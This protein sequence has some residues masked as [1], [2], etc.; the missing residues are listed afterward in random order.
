MFSTY[1]ADFNAVLKATE[2]YTAGKQVEVEDAFEKIID[3]FK[4]IKKQAGVVYLIGNGGSSGIVSHGAIDFLNA[5][6]FRSHALTDNSLLTCMANDYGYENVF[7]QP[8]KTLLREKDAVI[9]ISSSGNSMN[10]VNGSNLA[11]EK[12]AFVLTFSGFTKENKLRNAGDYNI[13][14]D[15]KHYGRV[16]IGHSL[17]LHYLTDRL[18]STK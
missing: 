9:A 13:W 7:A 16:E 18:A 6:G 14:L 5:C 15:S 1:L 12:G 17:L 8:F 4:E 2:M 11:K 10:I 3:H